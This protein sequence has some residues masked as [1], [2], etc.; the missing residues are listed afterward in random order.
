V[1]SDAA[2][3][4]DWNGKDGSD[5]FV[6]NGVYTARIV[7]NNENNGDNDKRRIVVDNANPTVTIDATGGTK[8]Q[9]MTITGTTTDQPAVAGA[10]IE[11]VEVSILRVSD[12]AVLASGLAT[13]TDDFA[14]WSFGYTPTEA[15]NQKVRAK[16]IDN[17]GNNTTTDLNFTVVTDNNPP[18]ANAGGPYTT[19]EGTAKLL[20]GSGSSDP[21]AGNNLTYLWAI[22]FTTTAGDFVGIDTGGECKFFDPGNAADP[23]T[24]TSTLQKPNVK[25]TDDGVFKLTLV[26]TDNHG[27]S[28]TPSVAKLAVNNVAPTATFNAPSAV[29]EGTAIALSL[30]NADDASSTDKNAG[31]TYAFDCG[32]G[33]GYGAFGAT[34]SG[35]CP[36]ND[37]GARTVK[38][39]VKDDDGGEREY[40]AAVSIE[41][42]KPTATFNAPTTVVEGTAI[43][44][45]LTNPFDPSSA[46]VAAGFTYAFDCG[47]GAGYGAFSSTSTAPCPTSDNGTRTVKGKIKDKDGSFTEYTA[48]VQI[49][50]EAP[51]VNAGADK[52]GKEGETIELSGSFTDP[53]TDDTHTWTW[54]YIEGFHAGATCTITGATSSLSPTISCNDDGTV[55]VTLTVKDDDGG[56]G[57]DGMLL[58]LSNVAPT[59]TLGAP[60][61]VEEG[62]AIALSLTSPHDPSSQDAAAGFT[63]AFD[64]GTTAGYSAFSSTSTASCPTTDNGTR[65][66]KGKIKD[67]DGDFTEYTAQVEITNAVPTVSAGTDKTGKEGET[68]TLGGSFTDPGTDDTHTWAWK[69]LEGFH[70]S[71]ACT[72]T[73]AT[74]SLTPTIKCDD[75]GTVQ[76]TL[77]VKDDDG[78][79]GSDQMLLTLS[80]V[81]PTATFT[82]PSSVDEGSPIAVSLTN[83]VDPSTVDVAAGL[84][85]AFDCGDGTGY[86][87]LGSATSAS[88]PT[89]DNGIRTVKGKIQDKDGDFT[90][91]SKTVEVKNV[92]P[93]ILTW[94]PLPATLVI[95]A[96]L[97]LSA[98]FSDP[99][100]DTH[101]AQ[102][103]CGSG[104]GTATSATSPH[105][106]LCPAFSSI[107]EH[108]IRIKIADDDGGVD[109]KIHKL[110]VVYNFAGFFAPVDRPNIYNVSKAGQAIP[111]KWRLTDALGRP[112]TD[113]T[114]VTVKSVSLNCATSAVSD[115]I[116]EY[117]TGSSG[118]QNLGDGN[119]QF[120]WKTPT[121]Y[122]GT[123]KSIA[124]VFGAGALSYVE[125]PHAFFTFKK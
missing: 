86:G 68:I 111:L 21:D 2:A 91:Y 124:L 55:Q 80:N 34:S 84:K 58:T 97:N 116:E 47:T 23:G 52:T 8:N 94:T 76:V 30:L 38:G 39:K 25:C 99:G 101:T 9:P 96:T 11:K 31:F 102:V 71:A 113:L 79:E 74:S 36:T 118:L 78:G 29:N 64:C 50:N 95:G 88:C 6:A 81:A 92:A 14:T 56:E 35:S 98:T 3:S 114:G 22:D 112:I 106:Y 122:A 43:A 54:K 93:T 85:Y 46:D 4:L 121:A 40:T 115:M 42:V 27:A 53:G 105:S 51:T 62:T 82:A 48:Q 73:G 108:T 69:Y 33:G 19:D 10:G 24:A 57:S 5:N 26:V 125:G 123:C 28:S 20:D 109:E 18:T 70:G 63:Y 7:G 83:P 120:N 119:Y 107:G 16:A 100:A 72:I 59:A 44:L 87:A 66:I 60:S 1:A 103:D 15:S 90:E 12:N 49:T 104:Y 65:T 32:D 89:T 117:A 75:D 110:T 17:A 67:K 41:S 13:T 77:T 45:S 61:P 37:D